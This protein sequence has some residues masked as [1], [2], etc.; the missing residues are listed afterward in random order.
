MHRRN[1]DLHRTQ[2]GVHDRNDPSVQRTGGHIPQSS[3]LWRLTP[4]VLL[5]TNACTLLRLPIIILSKILDSYIYVMSAVY[6]RNIS[7]WPKTY[8]YAVSTLIFYK[9]NCVVGN[10]WARIHDTHRQTHWKCL[11]ALKKRENVINCRPV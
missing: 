8:F 5:L 3:P 9:K 6:V 7:T 10:I 4:A 11:V 1:N 2:S